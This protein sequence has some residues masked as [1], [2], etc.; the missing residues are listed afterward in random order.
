MGLEWI[1]GGIWVWGGVGDGPFPSPL[2]G[3]GSHRRQARALA[4]FWILCRNVF[5][6]E[7]TQSITCIAQFW[8][9]VLRAEPIGSRLRLALAEEVAKE[10]AWAGKTESVTAHNDVAGLLLD[11]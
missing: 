9:T 3:F 2:L 6:V 1:W 10:L 4:N 11:R 7:E 8:R 5:P